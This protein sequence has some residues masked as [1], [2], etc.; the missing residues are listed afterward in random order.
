MSEAVLAGA[1]LSKLLSFLSI[2]Q[3]PLMKKVGLELDIISGM[4]FVYC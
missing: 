1:P 3:F 2:E 4:F